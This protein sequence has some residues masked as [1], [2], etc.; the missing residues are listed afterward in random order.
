M[1]K[2]W[3]DVPIRKGES[4]PLPNRN[5]LEAGTPIGDYVLVS[6]LEEGRGE[7]AELG[8]GAFG[9]VYLARHRVRREWLF[10]IKEYFPQELAIR[11][12]QD[13]QSVWPASG[14]A[15]SAF[16]DGMARFHRE[17][18]Q[19]RCLRNERHVVSCVNYFE[20]N[21]TAYLV[22]DYDDG[23]PLSKYLRLRESRGQPF[24]E[25][26]LLAVALPLLEGL[27]AVH[28][29]GTLHRD[30]K[31]G[32]VFVR[33]D[34][35][36]GG[37]PTE[38]VLMDFG[39]A[40]Q[41]H[42]GLHSRSK[43]PHTPGYAAWEQVSQSGS[44]SPA[45]DLYGVGALL[46]R[47]VAGGAVGHL[48]LVV[49]DEG[50]G[51]AEGEGAWSAE[52]PDVMKRVG[53]RYTG[54]RDP[55]PSA[56][57]VGS[58]RF[59]EPVLRAID[60]CLAID[61]KDR[62]QS[63]GELMKLLRPESRAGDRPPRQSWYRLPLLAGGGVVVLLSAALFF[64]ADMRLVRQN[65]LAS[66]GPAPQDQAEEAEEQA[67]GAEEGQQEDTEGRAER[68]AGPV[69][70]GSAILRVETE[71]AGAEVLVNGLKL[72]ETPLLRE[73]L[74]P[75]VRDVTLRYP[76]FE[77]VELSGQALLEDRVL[78][79]DRALKRGTGGL[80]IVTEPRGAWVESRGRRLANGTP[81]TLEGLPAGRFELTLGL[82][83]HRVMKAVAVVPKNGVGRLERRLEPVAYGSLTLELEPADASVTFR[84]RSLVYQSGM[85]L[86]EGSYELRVSRSGYRGAV[87]RV[88]VSGDTRRPIE[89]DL[90]RAGM[91]FHDTLLSGGAGPEMVVL[92]AG[93][94]RMGC[95]SGLDCSDYE[96][97]VH[98]VTV[99]QPFGVGRYEV[100]LAEWEACVAAGGCSSRVDESGWGGDPSRRPMIK[101]S[102]DDAQAYARWLSSE[103][104]ATYRLLSESEWEYAARAGSITAYTWGR[105]VGS[106]RANC[107]GCGSQW[108]DS[109][110]ALVGSFAANWWGLHDMHGNVWEW[111]E[112]CWNE[113]YA[114]APSNDGAWRNGDCSRRVVRGGSWFNEPW[115]LRSANRDWFGPDVRLNIIGF[116]VA[117]TLEVVPE[118][119]TGR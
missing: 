10:A 22:M 11:D 37:R 67:K 47:I 83:G 117:R 65:S 112:D 53:A 110:T 100:T 25:E 81:A 75:G 116:R 101:A 54:L 73:D 87:V 61:A 89:L 1:A 24:S 111:V 103:T 19:L 80:T 58:G 84:D 31:P 99:S 7:T 119:R 45:T 70:G 78:R 63:C 118:N 60:R 23:V 96:H 107:D 36:L 8:S 76:H 40:K 93:T 32:N 71:P 104:G 95:V 105:E 79:I 14:G 91:T 41:E 50:D 33:Q 66:G 30:I 38:A 6:A 27:S 35:D 44:L 17:A 59:S 39:A 29:V 69:L 113:S 109:Q 46:W 82:A 15:E 94:F 90:F 55:M 51:A 86:P 5:A 114:G 26:D 2:K 108:D 74:G 92:P 28:R 21:G 34:G 115:T 64:L 98:A 88:D 42:L 56:T 49:L 43:A 77:T 16:A 9:I 68:D 102:W 13:G 52:P 48:G 4:A 12:R 62:P 106:G 20:A 57:D 18:D 72:G 3:G 85:R 97:P